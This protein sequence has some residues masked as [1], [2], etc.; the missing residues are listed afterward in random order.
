M[1]EQKNAR[2]KSFV[3]KA[4]QRKNVLFTITRREAETSA[5]RQ[6]ADER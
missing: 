2:T 6:D 4:Q 3:Q 5:V 1:G